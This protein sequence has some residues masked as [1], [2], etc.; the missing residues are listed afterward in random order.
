MLQFSHKQFTNQKGRQMS[1]GAWTPR[2][3]RLRNFVLAAMFLFAWYQMY[4]ASFPEECRGV[5]VHEM[6]DTCQK[7]V[8]EAS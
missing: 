1:K 8:V 3:Y 7:Q 6:S 5:S 4:Q 2:A